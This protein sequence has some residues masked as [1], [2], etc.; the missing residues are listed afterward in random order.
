MYSKS[1]FHYSIIIFALLCLVAVACN[2]EKNKPTL[3]AP[4]KVKVIEVARSN[5]GFNREYSGTVST[6]QS[7]NV[8]FSVA[9]TITELYAQEAQRVTKGQLLGKVRNGDYLN[10]YNIAQAQL[11]EARDGYERLKKLHD[12]NALP[13]IKWV[14]IQQKLKQAQNAAEMAERTLNDANLHSPVSGTVTRKYADVGQTVAP[15]EPVY[16]IVSTA[17]LTI[18]IPVSENEIVDFN[19]GQPAKVSFESLG[20]DS[21]IGKVSQKSVTADPLTRSFTVKVSLPNMDGKILPGMIGNVVFDNPSYGDEVLKGIS[22]P[23]QAVLLNEDNRLFV[24]VV[25]DSVAQRRF[26]TADELT[27][28]GVFVKSGLSPG[29]KVIVEG[30]QKVGSGTR[31]C[32]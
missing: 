11:A 16:E 17:N 30:I 7:A 1:S 32:Y 2:K 9:G 27:S 4:V 21:I 6:S 12:A 5:D 18:D 29:D 15:M 14:E 31:V 26:V 24:W 23:S 10:T 22:L 25:S 19:V 13:E 28:D 20:A 3:P 8:S